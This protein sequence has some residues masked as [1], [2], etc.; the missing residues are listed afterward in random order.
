MAESLKLAP[1]EALLGMKVLQMEP[2]FSR[3]ELPFR[4][5]LTQPSGVVHGGAIAS[6]ADTA[7]A[8][9]LKGLVE[10]EDRYYTVNLTI[11]YR[12]P[13]KEG[14]AIAEARIAKFK[15]RVV[16]GEVI[17]QDSNSNTLAVANITFMKG[18][19]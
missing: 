1:F 5:E 3:I 8:L 16:L 18:T 12:A 13:F 19:K 11:K 9:S 14:S 2:G 15:A 17:V 10:E 6:L 7:V 4:S